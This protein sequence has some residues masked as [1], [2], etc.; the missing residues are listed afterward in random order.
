MEDVSKAE[1]LVAQNPEA[2]EEED[3]SDYLVEKETDDIEP[4]KPKRGYRSKQY[5]EDR[6]ND[7]DDG[8]I[9]FEEAA[10]GALGDRSQKRPPNRS[11]AGWNR[12]EEGA[13]I[14][15]DESDEAQ[16]QRRRRR[17]GSEE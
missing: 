1:L 17:R 15:E 4:R 2:A 11:A 7:F 6:K 14:S 12:E 10:S 5:V 8:D 3:D 9:V 16:Q 13:V